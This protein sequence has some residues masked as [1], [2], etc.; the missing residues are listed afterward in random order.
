MP[1]QP[2]LVQKLNPLNQLRRLFLWIKTNFWKNGGFK[3]KRNIVYLILF[4]YALYI[5]CKEQGLL[6]KKSIRG[7]HVFLT[8]AGSGLGRLLAIRMVKKGAHLT[9]IDVNEKTI[10]Q[11]KRMIKSQAGSDDNVLALTC[12]LVSRRQVS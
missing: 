10:Q 4:I 8:G 6:P 12:D 5:F 9:I 1:A 3:S 11:T 7:K 2:T